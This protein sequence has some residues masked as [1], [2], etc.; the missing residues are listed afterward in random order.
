MLKRAIKT[1][2]VPVIVKALSEIEMTP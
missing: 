1:L 2:K